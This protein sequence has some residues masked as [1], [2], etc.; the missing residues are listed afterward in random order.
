MNPF[1]LTFGKE[2]VNAISRDKQMNEIVEGF[3]SDN[4]EFHACMITGVRGSG[5]TVMLTEVS[6]EIGGNKDWIV[7]ELSPERDMLLALAAELSN[8]KEL[9][10]VFR[11]AKINLSFLGLGLEIDS[12]PPITD[13]VVALDRMLGR[14][15]DKGKKVLVAVD[16][17]VPNAH[18]REFASQFQI[19]IRKGYDVFLL[20]TGLYQNVYDL[21]NQETLTF[22]YRAPKFEMGPLNRALVAR[23]YQRVFDIPKDEAAAMARVVQGYPYAYQ[24]LGYLCYKRQ[25][26]YAEVLDEFDAYLAEYVYEKIW[27]ELSG[28]DRDV[29]DAMAAAESGKVGDI[30]GLAGMSSGEFSVYRDRLLKRGLVASD[31]FGYLRFTLPRFGEFAKSAY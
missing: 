15:T 21:Q 1:S 8:R 4:P 9:L 12:E 2:P 25:L 28:K 5:K 22:L 31:G 6:A 19:Y 14:L 27:S 11:D 30:R 10:Q 13:V 23:Q 24:V 3:V 26:P 20:M 7:A 18:V 17:A 16:E 29:V